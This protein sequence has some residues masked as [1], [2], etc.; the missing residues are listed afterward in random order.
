MQNTCTTS[1]KDCPFHLELPNDRGPQQG[2]CGV[3]RGLDVPQF[4]WSFR[5][6]K[7][8]AEIMLLYQD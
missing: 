8:S 4:G 1:V 5:L 7:L 3:L 6:Y 2:C